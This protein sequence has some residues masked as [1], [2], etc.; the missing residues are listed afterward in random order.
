MFELFQ[1]AQFCSK[2]NNFWNKE[3]LFFLKGINYRFFFTKVI[4]WTLIGMKFKTISKQPAG[5]AVRAV[6]VSL[7]CLILALKIVVFGLDRQFFCKARATKTI[8]LKVLTLSPS[9]RSPFQKNLAGLAAR[10]VF[11]CSFL[12]FLLWKQSF[13]GSIGHIFSLQHIPP[14]LFFWKFLLHLPTR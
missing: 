1:F 9:N 11:V 12:P 6:Y 7:F 5:L 13:L 10:A 4:T 8:F 3:E 2:N 14:K